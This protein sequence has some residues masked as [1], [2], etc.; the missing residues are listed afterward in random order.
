MQS[1]LQLLNRYRTKWHT[2]VRNVLVL[3]KTVGNEAKASLV[4]ENSLCRCCQSLC[5]T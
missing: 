3:V 5:L 4:A 1:R 2:S